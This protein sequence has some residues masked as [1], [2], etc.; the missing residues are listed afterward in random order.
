MNVVLNP[1]LETLVNQK[2]SSGEFP[3][4]EA[5]VEEGL[6]LLKVRDRAESRLE[7]LLLEAEES[8]PATEMSARGGTTFA[9]KSIRPER[10]AARCEPARGEAATGPAG[11]H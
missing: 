2:V 5:V 1:D 4:A 8:G 11:H 10:S 6:R 7:T 9:A 3:S